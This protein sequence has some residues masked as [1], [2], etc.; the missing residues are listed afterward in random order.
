MLDDLKDIDN[1]LTRL[2]RELDQQQTAVGYDNI[3]FHNQ[4]IAVL[5]KHPESTELIDFVVKINDKLELN[6]IMSREILFDT[7]KGVLLIKQSLVK[8]LIRESKK[9]SE[10]PETPLL[11]AFAFIKENKQTIIIIALSIVFSLVMV[12]AI[13]SPEGTFKVLESI[14]GFMSSSKAIK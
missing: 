10:K 5:A 6:H 9:S 7:I 12:S 8:T 14:K 3:L 2:I 11:K 1:E 13:V 4:M